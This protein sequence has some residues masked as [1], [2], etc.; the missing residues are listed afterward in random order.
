MFARGFLHRA[1]HAGRA[2]VQSRYGE[3]LTGH[4]HFP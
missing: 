2:K 1:V 4:F 3:F